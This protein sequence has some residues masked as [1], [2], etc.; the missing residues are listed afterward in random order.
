VDIAQIATG[1]FAVGT[2]ALVAW[3]PHHRRPKLSLAEDADRIQSRVEGD[4]IAYIRLLACNA[5]GKRVAKGTR[6]V[7][8]GYRRR[9]ERSLTSLASPL[10]TWPSA[11]LETEQAPTV[12][13]LPGGK[14][15]VSFGR[16]V[17]TPMD[18]RGRPL[19]VP[20]KES[21]GANFAIKHEPQNPSAA[22]MLMLDMGLTLADS[23]EW[24]PPDAW[25]VQLTIGSDESDAQTFDVH[26]AWD[27]EAPDAEA[28]RVSLLDRLQV[29]RA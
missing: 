27:G 24:L 9:E 4:G 7:L 29:E 26:V 25:I 19:R 23:R 13:I 18:S 28:A 16:L 22:W 2:A 15:P 6:V 12:V 10:M 11:A 1:F 21:G 3:L 17:R 8:E 5:K 20:I 14:R